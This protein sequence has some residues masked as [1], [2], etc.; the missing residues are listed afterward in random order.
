MN[1]LCVLCYI[2]C[3]YLTVV[4]CCEDP[5]FLSSLWIAARC[6]CF[7]Y[8]QFKVV[9]YGHFVSCRRHMKP[10]NQTYWLWCSGT[11]ALCGTVHPVSYLWHWHIA[12]VNCLDSGLP[13]PAIFVYWC[14]PVSRENW[15]SRIMQ[16]LHTMI[17][18]LSSSDFMFC[19]LLPM[20]FV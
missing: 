13:W 11:K 3:G 8:I 14:I 19:C 12:V 17:L 10:L 16:Q 20:F 2:L 6:Y 15:V 5:C 1:A 18:I 4:V 7:C 9:G